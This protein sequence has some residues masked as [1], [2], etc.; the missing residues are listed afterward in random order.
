MGGA[1]RRQGPRERALRQAEA[2]ELLTSLD[3][4]DDE[5]EPV[6]IGTAA[7]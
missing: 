5:A 1:H 2:A 7:T 3:E 4:E 6:T